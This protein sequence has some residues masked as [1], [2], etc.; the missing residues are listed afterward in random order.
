V[1]GL[2]KLEP[3]GRGA[4]CHNHEQQMESEPNK[5]EWRKGI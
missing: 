2:L 4:Q 5:E 1:H 3:I